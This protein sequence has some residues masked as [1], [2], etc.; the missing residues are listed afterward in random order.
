[1]LFSWLGE[2]LGIN[3]IRKRLDEVESR[4]ASLEQSTELILK[5]F[6]NFK[7]RTE[8][9]LKLMKSQIEDLLNLIENVL[10]T[11]ENQEGIGRAKRLKT[12]LKNNLTR[13]SNAM[14]SVT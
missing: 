1:M 2:K 7:N 9:E 8:G 13:I 4:V 3:E 6:G 10:T 5:N 14:R 12:R 11:L